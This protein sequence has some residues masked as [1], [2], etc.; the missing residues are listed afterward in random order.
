MC[1]GA[2]MRVQE[3]LYSFV[4][5][6]SATMNENN[7]FCRSE[8]CLATY[9]FTWPGRRVSN[10]SLDKEDFGVVAVWHVQ[11]APPLFI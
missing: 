7:L 11:K 1:V 2:C 10:L 8:G 6:S 9:R 5:F 4:L 3:L